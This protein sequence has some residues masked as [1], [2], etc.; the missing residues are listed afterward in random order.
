MIILE[1]IYGQFGM[2]WREF[3]PELETS[4]IKIIEKE[5]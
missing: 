4:I 3:I 5:S 2:W 1:L